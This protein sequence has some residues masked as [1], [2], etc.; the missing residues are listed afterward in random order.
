MVR[1][2]KFLRREGGGGLCVGEP[3]APPP[4]E[5]IPVK[6]GLAHTAP[7]LQELQEVMAKLDADEGVDEGVQAAPHEGHALGNIHGVQEIVFIFAVLSSAP[8]CENRVPK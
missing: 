1:T 4:A 8:R 2:E 6:N 5:G 7:F 3:R